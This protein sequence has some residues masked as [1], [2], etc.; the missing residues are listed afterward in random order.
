MGDK[1][2]K[3]NSEN[4]EYTYQENESYKIRFTATGKGGSNTKDSLLFVTSAYEYYPYTIENK[5]AYTIV[6][7]NNNPT[8]LLHNFAE[9][10]IPPS[11][12]T[13]IKIRA[14]TD[15]QPVFKSDDINLQIIHHLR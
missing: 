11:S 5:S 1:R 3:S 7:Y 2:G 4:P 6:A 9:V 13:I 12:K 14:S 10:I 8:T 15:L